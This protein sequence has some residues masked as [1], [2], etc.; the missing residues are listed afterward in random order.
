MTH[1][2]AEGERG[3]ELAPVWSHVLATIILKRVTKT[4]T[5]VFGPMTGR[6]IGW[7]SREH[8][9]ESLAKLIHL[10]AEDYYGPAL[11]ALVAN[12]AAMESVLRECE[13]MLTNI[14]TIVAEDGKTIMA[15][16][17]TDQISRIDALTAKGDGQ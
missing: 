8:D 11:A 7:D 15:Q 16:K 14:R 5:D 6:E 2:P 3:Q 10:R 17:I 9:T 12:N 1:Q 4:I 13:T